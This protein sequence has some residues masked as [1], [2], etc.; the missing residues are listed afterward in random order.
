MERQTERDKRLQIKE[1]ATRKQKGNS[2]QREKTRK[3][4]A[5]KT[6]KREETRARNKFRKATRPEPV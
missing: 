3:V 1:K 6:E 2:D 5:Q 4:K